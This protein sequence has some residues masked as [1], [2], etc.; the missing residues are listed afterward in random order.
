MKKVRTKI[1]IGVVIQGPVL[2]EGRTYASLKPKRFDSSAYIKSYFEV[3]TSLGCEA[4][5]S[6]WQGEPIEKLA[7]IPPKHILQQPY[8]S[9]R[10][11]NHLQ[12][13]YTNNKYK[14]FT[15]IKHGVLA[16]QARDCT[17][18]IKVRSD[19][20]INLGEL[21]KSL[22]SKKIEVE[23]GKIVTPLMYLKKP[24]MF[25]DGYF[26]ALT[27]D[28]ID[29][30]TIMLEEKE[31]FASVHQDVF[32]KWA[33]HTGGSKATFKDIYKIYGKTNSMSTAQLN[34]VC[35]AWKK[36]FS[37]LPKSLWEDQDW[38]GE[39]ITDSEIKDTYFFLEDFEKGR[40][41]MKNS[42]SKK[43]NIGL[44]VNLAQA[45]TFFTSSKFSNLII[46]LQQKLR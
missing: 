43:L 6:T 9:Y 31:L 18:V 25:Y 15:S 7:K 22:H 3:A 35:E 33:L 10:P 27:E 17:H 8:P 40:Q 37:V 34:F 42:T 30:C 16:L 36:S 26:L 1:K 41:L 29:L 46:R 38:R 13:D 24:N 23:Q 32:Y 28:M 12:N 21:V 39:K 2:S 20:Q 19:L 11:L 4:V 14:Q 44:K 45:T 5:L